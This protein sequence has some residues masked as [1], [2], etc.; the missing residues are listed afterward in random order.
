MIARNDVDLKFQGEINK[1]CSWTVNSQLQI[2]FAKCAVLHL[3]LRNPKTPYYFGNDQILV[4]QNIRDLRVL[5]SDDLKFHDHCT[6]LYST[7]MRSA[8]LILKCFRSRSWTFLL[9]LFKTFVRSKIEYSSP[10]WNPQNIGDIALLERVQCTFTRRVC[11]DDTL[12]CVQ[13]LQLLKLDSLELRR[14]IADQILVF[15]LLNN[16]LDVDWRQFL[17]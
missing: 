9:N 3:G 17:L 14:L 12:S 2:A 16:K 5:I 7:A 13:R 10:V 15:K 1:L 6:T 8:N 4:V 11:R